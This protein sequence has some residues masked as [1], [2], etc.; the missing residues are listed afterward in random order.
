V[1]AGSAMASA[2]AAALALTPPRHAGPARRLLV[3]GDRRD[4]GVAAGVLTLAGSAL[5]RFAVL[6]AGLASARDPDATTM[7]QRRRLDARRPAQ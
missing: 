2:G 5:Q 3:A 7:P 1:F 4:G 6:E